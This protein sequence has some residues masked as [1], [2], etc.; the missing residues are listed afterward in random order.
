VPPAIPVTIPELFTV[1]TDTLL[2]DHTPPVTEFDKTVVDPA[3]S[4][5]EPVIAVN[6][7]NVLT[8]II[9]FA[10]VALGDD[11]VSLSLVHVAWMTE[12]QY[13]F[14]MGGRKLL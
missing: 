8:V 9:A 13:V 12:A 4:I 14:Y 1:A 10:A 7:G 5:E 11:A 2:L 6:A 3:H